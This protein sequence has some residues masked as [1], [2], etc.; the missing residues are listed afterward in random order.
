MSNG[1]AC[2]YQSAQHTGNQT[3]EGSVVSSRDTVTSE[4][5]VYSSDHTH[6]KSLFLKKMSVEKKSGGKGKLSC[7]TPGTSGQLP[8][9]PGTEKYKHYLWYG[10]RKPGIQWDTSSITLLWR[11]TGG[12]TPSSVIYSSD[13]YFN[14]CFQGDT[15]FVCLH[16]NGSM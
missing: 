12:G 9:R 2:D 3:D 4:D 14:S 11:V 5:E 7:H 15:W 16:E 6:R 10:T 8:T 13:I 1:K